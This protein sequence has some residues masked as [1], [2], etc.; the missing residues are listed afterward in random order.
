MMAATITV[1]GG[2]LRVSD[3]EVLFDLPSSTLVGD[4]TTQ[5]DVSNDGRFLMLRTASGD[6][7]ESRMVIVRNFLEE[8]K[9]RV[10]S[11]N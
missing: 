6:E 5:Y 10:G 1:N 9:A 2:E 8:V 3:R 11:G 7:D 4:R